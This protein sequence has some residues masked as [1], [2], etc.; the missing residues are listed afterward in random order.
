MQRFD[1]AR[2]GC[3]IQILVDAMNRSRMRPRGI[4]PS[5]GGL[6]GALG[7][8]TIQ[9]RRTRAGGHQGR[10]DQALKIHGDIE[11]PA[12]QFAPRSHDAPHRAGIERQE[13]IDETIPGNQIAPFR[14]H[15]PGDFGTGHFPLQGGNGGQ[16]MDDVPHCAEAHHQNSRASR[17]AGAPLARRSTCSKSRRVTPSSGVS[18]PSAAPSASTT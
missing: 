15:H 5:R 2:R 9:P 13:P 1:G 18:S 11:A 16:R 3:Q 8:E 14:L 4:K 6:A 7:I 10:F 12:A 17:H